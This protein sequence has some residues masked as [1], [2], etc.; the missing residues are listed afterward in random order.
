MG[1][2]TKQDAFGK[3][4]IDTV[5]NNKI[6]TV[7]EIGS[8]DGTGSTQCFIEGMQNFEN[9]RLICLEVFTDRFKQLCNNTSNYNWIKCY[10]QSSISYNN[11]LY[12]DFNKIWESPFNFI[13][14]QN[15]NGNNKPVVNQWFIEDIK[16]INNYKTGYI[17][18]HLNDIY[19]AVLIDGSEF[20][21][22]SE[23]ILLKDKVNFFILDDSYSAFKTSQVVD[24][25]SKDKDWELIANNKHTRNGWAIFKRKLI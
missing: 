5:A 25:L 19:D 22:Y 16:T 11:M 14:K 3:A 18:D 12:K 15:I 23:F 20:T 10:N 24:E 6:Q 17:E 13:P 8:W 2:I 4:I 1:E 9:K 7:V 21:G